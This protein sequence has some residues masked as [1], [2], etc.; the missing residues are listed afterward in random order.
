MAVIKAKARQTTSVSRVGEGAE[1]YMRMLRDGTVGIADLIALWSLEGRIFTVTNGQSTTPR[2]WQASGTLDTKEFDLH[3]AVPASVVIIP[4]SLEVVFE[5]YGTTAVAELMLQY[6]TGSV[7]GT[8]TSDTPTSSNANA[9]ISSACTCKTASATGTAL[10]SVTE[11]IWH[12]MLQAAE[13]VAS[14]G[15]D[16]HWKPQRFEYIAMKTGV[17]HVV[18]P[19]VQLV[20]FFVSQA[21]TGFYTFKYAELPVGSVE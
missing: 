21:P 6:G 13:T 12:D 5:T 10:T 17:L 14:A 15:E 4:L 19:S 11:E 9:G 1:N 2:T 20:G 18:G 3:I 16:V 8:A 7:V